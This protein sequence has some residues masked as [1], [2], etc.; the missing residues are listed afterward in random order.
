VYENQTS[1]GQLHEYG[2]A[3]LAV[4]DIDGGGRADLV[5]DYGSYGLW[6]Y[7]H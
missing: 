2:P 4:G 7:R 6:T 1:W 5:A 3:R